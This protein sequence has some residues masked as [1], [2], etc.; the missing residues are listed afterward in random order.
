MAGYILLDLE[1]TD[2]EGFKKYLKLAGPRLQ[3]P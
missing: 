2:P 1:I 3:H